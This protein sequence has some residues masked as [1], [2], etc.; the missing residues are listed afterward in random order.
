MDHSD[1]EGGGLQRT[2]DLLDM[3][4]D[5]DRA[6]VGQHQTD[7]HLH[8]RRLPGAVLAENAVNLTAMHL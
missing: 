1:A 6:L 4:I 8:Q 7:Q 3:A 2:L 5:S